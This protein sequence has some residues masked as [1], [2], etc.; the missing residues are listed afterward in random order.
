MRDVFYNSGRKKTPQLALGGFKNE[1]S[2]DSNL[3][4]PLRLREKF[5]IHYEQPV[6]KK[7][8]LRIA[9]SIISTVAIYARL[10]KIIKRI[11]VHAL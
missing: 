4:A 2:P 8:L 6:N 3:D 9:R 1:M 5:C 11:I 7:K 10:H